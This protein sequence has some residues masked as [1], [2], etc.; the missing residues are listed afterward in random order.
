MVANKIGETLDKIAKVHYQVISSDGGAVDTMTSIKEATVPNI[1]E[2]GREI[3]A[4]MEWSERSY[5]FDFEEPNGDTPMDNETL[6]NKMV[7]IC[8]CVNVFVNEHNETLLP[9]AKQIVTMDPCDL[10]AAKIAIPF[11]ESTDFIGELQGVVN[12]FVNAHEEVLAEHRM[13]ANAMKDDLE[14]V[15][16]ADFSKAADELNAEIQTEI[17]SLE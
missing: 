8:D 13:K 17:G 9:I 2:Q 15:A 4:A 10:V 12:K 16:K 7:E 1:A 11:N 5:Q 14:S 3:K 6:A